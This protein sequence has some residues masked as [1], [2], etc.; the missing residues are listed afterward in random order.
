MLRLIF[1]RKKA[2]LGSSAFTYLYGSINDKRLLEILKLEIKWETLHSYQ[3]K[4]KKTLKIVPCSKQTFNFLCVL[5]TNT[6][7]VGINKNRHL[8]CGCA[9]KHC[10]IS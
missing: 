1:L 10:K 7:D 5:K 9:S 4:I 2:K 6:Y 3:L 8:L